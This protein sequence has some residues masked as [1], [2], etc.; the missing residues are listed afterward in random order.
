MPEWFQL[1]REERTGARL[2]LNTVVT[3]GHGEAHR[4]GHH[5]RKEL[6]SLG[7]EKGVHPSHGVVVSQGCRD[8]IREV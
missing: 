2:P 7:H 4:V 1:L 8:F 6:D 5:V 3:V